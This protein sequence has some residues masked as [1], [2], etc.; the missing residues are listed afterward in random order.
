MH[1]SLY[2]EWNNRQN[3]NFK[4]QILI[5][6]IILVVYVIRKI[7]AVVGWWRTPFDREL[8][9]NQ[10]CELS[11]CS[12]CR[13][14]SI[15]TLDK[16]YSIQVFIHALLQPKKYLKKKNLQ[17]SYFSVCLFAIKLFNKKNYIDFFFIN[18]RTKIQKALMYI[19]RRIWQQP[20]ELYQNL[21]FKLLTYPKMRR[22]A[23]TNYQNDPTDCGWVEGSS[24]D[25]AVSFSPFS[26][27]LC[28]PHT[29]FLWIK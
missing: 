21:V 20:L 24:W 10:I 23:T 13:Y 4:N 3:K 27:G 12:D 15:S 6:A 5:N 22:T 1:R 2:H 18:S 14:K 9:Y 16:D 17:Y 7:Q 29:W 8:Y 28:F 11:Y 26:K 25:S 19:Y